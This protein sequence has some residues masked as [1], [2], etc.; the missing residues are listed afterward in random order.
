MVF[1]VLRRVAVIAA[2]LSA[3]A[4][5]S[6]ATT[7]IEFS[8]TEFAGFS[9]DFNLLGEKDGIGYQN[10]SAY[11]S[12]DWLYLHDDG[13]LHQSVF[14]SDSGLRFDALSA[15]IRGYTRAFRTGKDKYDSGWS[16]ARYDRWLHDKELE[17]KNLGWYGYRDGVLVASYTGR[18]DSDTFEAFHFSDDFTD[19]DTLVAAVLL[20]KGI[21][22]YPGGVVTKKKTKYCEDWCAGIQV[23][24]L[25]L[26]LDAEMA[27]VPLPASGVLLLAG[28][29]GFGLIA[30]RRRG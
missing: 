11:F 20:P 9:S 2:L 15:D 30:R 3:P 25:T 6:A 1:R 8:G 22:T 7:D 14:T 21:D 18:I 10:S 16:D 23:D 24:R 17:F 12:G 4:V 26:K 28:L 29:A 13:G 19:L 27:P 5:A